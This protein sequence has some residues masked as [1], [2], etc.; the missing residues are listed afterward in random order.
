MRAIVLSHDWIAHELGHLEPWLD[1]RG[2]AVSRAYREHGLDL[3]EADLLIV[4][5]SPGSVATG[6]RGPSADREVALVAEWVG[7][8]RPYLGLCFGAQVLAC[9]LGG[10]VRRLPATFRGY[11]PV[12]VDPT[13]PE[14]TGPWTI[15]HEDAIT[16]PH[17]AAIVGVLPHADLVFRRG[18]AWG[19]QPHVEV[20][21]DT[22]R[23]MAEGLG[24]RPQVYEPLAE[25]LAADAHASERV[26][27]LLD[28]VLE[29]APAEPGDEVVNGHRPS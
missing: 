3:P 19:I 20:T 13:H 8:G 22:L 9:A 18:R 14:A 2:I 11:L 15:W 1:I 29:V 27:T 21:P 17:D 16:A 10:S 5:G 28:S 26:R 4:M 25:A 12:D 23:R 24:A 7:R 6:Y